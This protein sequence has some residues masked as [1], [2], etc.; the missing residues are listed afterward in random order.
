MLGGGSVASALREPDPRAVAKPKQVVVVAVGDIAC[1]PTDKPTA[2]TCRQRRTFKL[3]RSLK[4]D[5]VLALG[6]LQYESG[7]LS[8]FRNG[9]AKTWGRLLGRTYPIPGNHEYH[10]AGATGYYRYFKTRQPGSPGY[11]AFNL[12]GWSIYALNSNCEAISCPTEYRWLKRELAAKP[13]Q[14][15]IF[16]MHH[17]RFSSG[18]KHGSD[19]SMSRFFRI[20]QAHSVEM[21]LAGHEHVYERFH[22]M[23][24]NGEVSSDGVLS[25]VA[26][27]GGKSLYHF[28]KSL[29]GSAY[30]R[31]GHF[32]VLRLALRR[33]EFRFAFKDVNGTTPDSGTR[34]CR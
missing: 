29:K 2:T 20:A 16:T 7:S 4:P 24:A 14:C 12:G 23:R 34:A 17:P 6:D 19:A 13:R 9:Y 11:Y 26:G 8:D 21:I 15:S 31:A 30:R 10:T 18:V 5:A 28:G 22:R 27:T 33:T 32:G 25:F 3:A 1:P